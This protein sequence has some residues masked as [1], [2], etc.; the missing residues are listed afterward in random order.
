[1]V[2][3]KICLGI[4][5][6]EWV[7]LQNS[8]S[9][10]NFYSDT[11]HDTSR[12]KRAISMLH[13][14]CDPFRKQR[15]AS[16]TWARIC[17]LSRQRF[18]TKNFSCRIR[19]RYFRLYLVLSIF[20]RSSPAVDHLIRHQR[21]HAERNDPLNVLA[22]CSFRIARVSRFYIKSEAF[23]FSYS[24]TRVIRTVQNSRANEDS[25]IQKF[26]EPFLIA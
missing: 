5:L 6:S 8:Y 22:H 7:G 18:C 19:L 21:S 4:K 13:R 20:L 24:L 16:F 23:W 14:D 11:R 9:L 15:H 25:I 12:N 2:P 3:D 1:M 26:L 10:Y 17:A